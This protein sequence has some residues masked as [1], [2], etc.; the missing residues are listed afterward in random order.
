MDSLSKAKLSSSTGRAQN[1]AIVLLSAAAVQNVVKEAQVASAAA[2]VALAAVRVAKVVL[3]VNGVIVV[4]IA[5]KDV[6]VE[7][8]AIVAAIS[9]TVNRF[10][11]CARQLAHSSSILPPFLQSQP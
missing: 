8:V 2:L 3:V 1:S 6:A 10:L 7:T 9:T 4:E 5:A 11:E